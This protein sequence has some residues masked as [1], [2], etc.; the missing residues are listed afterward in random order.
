VP[1][2]AGQRCRARSR[3]TTSGRGRAAT[4]VVV[5]VTLP[6]RARRSTAIGR[7]AAS[8]SLALTRGRVAAKLV[9]T[10]D[11]VRCVARH[12][13]ARSLF[14][15]RQNF[16]RLAY[17]ARSA[18]RVRARGHAATIEADLTTHAVA[19]LVVAARRDAAR[20]EVRSEA[21]FAARAVTRLQTAARRRWRAAA[22]I[23][24]DGLSWRRWTARSHREDNEDR[25]HRS[26]LSHRAHYGFNSTPNRMNASP[27]IVVL[28]TS[29]VVDIGAY[30]AR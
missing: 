30:S 19:E 2:R 28:S 18:T 17:E 29:E 23:R 24:L 27:E 5:A 20:R 3:R 22:L 13:F 25:S 16:R 15:A 4:G 21:R 7:H 9:G 6:T 11:A 26:T 14:R 10:R 1:E 12:R 8:D